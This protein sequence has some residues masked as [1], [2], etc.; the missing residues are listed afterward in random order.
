MLTYIFGKVGRNRFTKKQCELVAVEGLRELCALWFSV[1]PFAGTCELCLSGET[2]LLLPPEIMRKE[3]L[4]RSYVFQ[5]ARLS[6]L[7]V[8]SPNSLCIRR[9]L[10]EALCCFF[11]VPPALSPPAGCFLLMGGGK[12]W[13]RSSTSYRCINDPATVCGERKP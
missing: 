12:S 11:Q 10:H 8:W 9:A 5:K 4:L 1:A 2:L 13:V 6:Y 7:L 3:Q